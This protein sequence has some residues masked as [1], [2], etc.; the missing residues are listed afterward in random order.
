MASH[1]SVR[2]YIKSKFVLFTAV[3]TIL[4]LLSSFYGLLSTKILLIQLAA[5]FYNIGINTVIV[6]YF[7]TRSYK[8]IDISKKA[9][10]NYQGTG[11]AQ[12]VY[13]LLIFLVP[14]VIYLPFKFMIGSTAGVV[15]L[16]IAGLI[17]FFLQDW[18]VDVLTREFFK[19]KYLILEGFRQ[20]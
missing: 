7:G 4:L 15:A 18:W 11:A 14:M 17:S 20:K 8:A 2:T 16:G 9:A 13:S 3:C 12:W 5:Y 10:F 6:V 19:R 1:L